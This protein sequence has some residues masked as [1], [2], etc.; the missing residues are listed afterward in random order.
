MQRN[1][2]KSCLFSLLLGQSF[3]HFLAPFSSQLNSKG[4]KSFERTWGGEKH[5]L[6]KLCDK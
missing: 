3:P 1:L 4:E 5:Y 6:K 2:R